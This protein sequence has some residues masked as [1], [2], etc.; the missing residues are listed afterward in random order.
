MSPCS[1]PS[2]RSGGGCSSIRGWA[3]TKVHRVLQHAVGWEDCHLHQYHLESGEWI[4]RLSYQVAAF[5]IQIVNEANVALRD[6]LGEAGT[7]VAYEYDFGD[8]W[9]HVLEVEAV[10]EGDAIAKAAGDDA[11]ADLP[12]A[13]CVA[14]ERAGP[15]EDSGG[16][17]GYQELLAL[18]AL[19]TAQKAKLDEWLRERLEWM[20]GFD[21]EAFD[22]DEVNR[23][24]RRVK[25]RK[26]F[27]GR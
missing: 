3:S 7:R 16:L 23:A 9:M 20:E 26:A 4:G 2:P 25:V 15:L 12:A 11:P 19:P 18:H 27:A 6:V 1:T 22:R 5:G 14:G 17:Y 21:P 13:W 8:G 10:L 24:I